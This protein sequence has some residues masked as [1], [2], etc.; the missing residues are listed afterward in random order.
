MSKTSNHQKLAVL[1]P[2]LEDL[3]KNK[4]SRKGKQQPK[5]L[6]KTLDELDNEN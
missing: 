3:K 2:Y 4:K 1:K 5:W 6:L